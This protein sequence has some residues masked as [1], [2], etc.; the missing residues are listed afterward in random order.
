M[1]LFFFFFQAED[2]IRDRD[3]TGVQTCALPIWVAAR[4]AAGPMW[5]MQAE[6]VSRD[7]NTLHIRKRR[8]D[9]LIVYE[10]D[11]YTNLAEMAA[12]RPP[13]PAPLPSGSR[14]A[15]PSSIGSSILPTPSRTRR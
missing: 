10:A 6:S 2:G 15:L 7:G 8:G 9:R 14:N 11:L 13:L 4:V 3:V 5:P 12:T 1:Y